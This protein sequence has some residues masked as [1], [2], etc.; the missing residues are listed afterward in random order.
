MFHLCWIVVNWSVCDF[1]VCVLLCVLNIAAEEPGCKS[2]DDCPQSDTCLGR[3]CV[4]PCT[5]SNPCA[6]SAECQAKNHRAVCQCPSG[7]TG[8]PF[9]NCYQGTLMFLSILKLSRLL[10]PDK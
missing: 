7:L 1:E 3:Q 8:N 2:S 5:V 4:N 6:P 10:Q 9:I